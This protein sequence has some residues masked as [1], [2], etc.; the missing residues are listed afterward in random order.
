[1][2]YKNVAGIDFTHCEKGRCVNCS[3]AQK[4]KC[5]KEVNKRK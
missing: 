4:K 1:M 2:S 3:A 5:E